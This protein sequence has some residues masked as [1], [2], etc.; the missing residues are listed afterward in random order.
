MSGRQE[1]DSKA[2]CMNWCRNVT[3]TATGIDHCNLYMHWVCIAIWKVMC[4]VRLWGRGSIIV[5]WKTYLLFFVIQ[6]SSCTPVPSS[7]SLI[8]FSP[9]H[10][11]SPP[12]HS[13]SSPTSSLAPSPSSLD[14]T[15][16]TVTTA[17]N[18]SSSQQLLSCDYYAV[19]VK[20]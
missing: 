19:R 13:P 18:C 15:S 1:L 8:G 6:E 7:T 4:A 10:S 5:G 14:I 12:T 9:T 3:R 17:G 2:Q 11:P 20:G 16:G